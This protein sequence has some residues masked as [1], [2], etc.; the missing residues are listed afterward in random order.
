MK[1]QEKEQKAKKRKEKKNKYFAF[2]LGFFPFFL[3]SLFDVER[4]SLL[5][6]LFL[7]F[8]Y[9]AYLVHSEVLQL[10]NLSSLIFSS[11]F[12]SFFLT[13]F[14]DLS[15]HSDVSS[16]LLS[17]GTDPSWSRRTKSST[18]RF[19][20]DYHYTCDDGLTIRIEQ[21]G[22]ESVTMDT[23]LGATVW[24]GGII[25]AKYFEWNVQKGQ[26]QLRS[27]VKSGPQTGKQKTKKNKHERKTRGLIF[28]QTNIDKGKRILEL[29]SGTGISGLVCAALG[30]S[31]LRFSLFF[32]SFLLCI[33]CFTFFS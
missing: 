26:V 20:D 11:S 7:F 17:P 14:S 6:F 12:F 1:Q 13:Y 2:D 18:Q 15:T 22:N 30:I 28:Q 3:F 19:K 27:N 29:G 8:S 4:C 25:L 32:F 9:S 5:L 16:D 21:A 33:P 24:D 10:I 23:A 31:T